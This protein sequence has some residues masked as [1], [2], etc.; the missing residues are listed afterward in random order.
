MPHDAAAAEA[1]LA[2]K[3]PGE[4]MSSHK[5]PV[6]HRLASHA[7]H[8]PSAAKDA[9]SARQLCGLCL[10]TG[11]RLLGAKECSGPECSWPRNRLLSPTPCQQQQPA[12]RGRPGWELLPAQCQCS[13]RE[14][15]HSC[16][17]YSSGPHHAGWHRWPVQV[18]TSPHSAVPLPLQA[19]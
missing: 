19:S 11:A 2:W 16:G 6:R 13:G 14:C 5:F 18:C 12:V 1:R 10:S 15:I 4:I 17:F 9:L 7:P 8:I 3:T